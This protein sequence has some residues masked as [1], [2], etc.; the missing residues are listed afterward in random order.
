MFGRLNFADI[1]LFVVMFFGVLFIAFMSSQ[2]SKLKQENRLLS[3]Q[4][5]QLEKQEKA[6]V[7]RLE[8]LH[9]MTEQAS[10]MAEKNTALYQ[11]KQNALKVAN[12]K[13][14]N[15]ANQPVPDDVIR[16]L[17]AAH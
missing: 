10:K 1:G 13:H 5:V 16:L 2:N 15:W 14:K 17:N 7:Q 9:A 3:Q 4:V 11:Q 6:M 8:R 12:E